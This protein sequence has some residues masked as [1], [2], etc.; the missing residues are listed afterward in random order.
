MIANVNRAMSA[1]SSNSASIGTLIRLPRELRDQIYGYYLYNIYLVYGTRNR[2]NPSFYTYTGH[3]K[4]ISGRDQSKSV[5]ASYRTSEKDLEQDE[6]LAKE[7]KLDTTGADGSVTEIT[8]APS[9]LSF[10]LVCKQVYHELADVLYAQK[11]IAP[12]YRP[13]VVEQTCS[14]FIHHGSFDEY[15]SLH[16]YD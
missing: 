2:D 3:N 12:S 13:R 14:D 11:I 1:N 5:S 8:A 4:D 16:R 7:I 15:W 9:H 6:T 10:F